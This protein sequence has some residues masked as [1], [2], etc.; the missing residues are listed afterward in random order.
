MV[1]WSMG[2]EHS[3][4]GKPFTESHRARL[5]AELADLRSRHSYGVPSR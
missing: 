4:R 2:P 1:V 5:K 3:A